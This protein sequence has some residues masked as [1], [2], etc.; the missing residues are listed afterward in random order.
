MRGAPVGFAW[1]SAARTPGI[2]LLAATI[3]L[4][5][6]A[7]CGGGSAPAP[8]APFEGALPVYAADDIPS[9]LGEAV[10]VVVDDGARRCVGLESG[11]Q[12]HGA[13]WPEGFTLQRNPYRIVDAEGN[14]VAEEG[15]TITFGGGEVPVGKLPNSCQTD[16]VLIVGQ[17]ES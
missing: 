9:A 13:L 15:D 10:V 5:L 6:G 4:A 7:G 3:A 12:L 16:T 14:L 1:R 17:V 11:G 2:R 8:N